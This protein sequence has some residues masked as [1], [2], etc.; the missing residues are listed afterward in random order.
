VVEEELER[1]DVIYLEGGDHRCLLKMPAEQFAE[2]MR[3]AVHARIS[4]SPL[5]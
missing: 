5:H 1:R 4:K 2:L 3:T